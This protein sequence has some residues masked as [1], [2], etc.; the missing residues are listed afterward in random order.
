MDQAVQFQLVFEAEAMAAHVARVRLLA[1][2]LGN[3]QHQRRARAEG[4][5]AIAA[6]EREHVRVRAIVHEQGGLLLERFAADVADVRPL[7]C[8]DAPVVFDVAPRREHAAAQV[9]RYV[10]DASVS[11]FQV[12]R[13]TL[14]HAESLAAQVAS[15]QPLARVD[16][17]MP[18]KSVRRI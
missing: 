8:M 11:L 15:K 1:G 7:A 3:V 14:M 2:V 9:A 4:L 17:Q 16:T 12:S 13:Q 18:V 6:F 10:L 5:V